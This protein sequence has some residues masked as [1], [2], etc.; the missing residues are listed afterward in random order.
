MN[1]PRW[2]SALAAI[3]L[4][5]RGALVLGVLVLATLVGGA[6]GRL[7]AEGTRELSASE[8]AAS[9]GDA[10]GAV[11]HARRAAMAYVPWAP[12]V[13]GAYRRLRDLAEQSE[14]RGDLEGA[15]FAWRAVRIASIG[16]RAWVL[17]RQRERAIAD[18]AIARLSAS[19]ALTGSGKRPVEV[20]GAHRERLSAEI[21]P[22]AG[23]GALVLLGV[24]LL[25]AAG[26]RLTARA[27]DGEGTWDKREIRTALVLG[28]AGV[29][30]W[31]AGLLLV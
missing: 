20:S 29:V 30:A 8:A 5:A 1:L 21:G 6:V 25:A 26:A 17:P 12:H 11:V 18:Q 22:S 24:L 31:F 14:A 19:T 3:A 23:W 7:L 13:G 9:S 28:A 10:H 4:R 2:A 27:W 15:L 16:T